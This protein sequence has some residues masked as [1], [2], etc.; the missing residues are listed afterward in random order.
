MEANNLSKQK[1]IYRIY[2]SRDGVLH[3]ERYP[4][5]YVNTN[6]VYFKNGRKNGALGWIYTQAVLD[7]VSC[8]DPREA[9]A[10]PFG[11]YG[12]NKYIWKVDEDNIEEVFTELKKRHL[13]IAEK[14]RKEW[15]KN[16]LEIAKREYELALEDYK[17]Y[18]GEGNV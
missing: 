6:A 17:K 15:V 18:G 10:T 16:R 1:Y 8:I 5:V 14:N 9:N 13:E 11:R 12:I 3:Y 4:V 2:E 7:D